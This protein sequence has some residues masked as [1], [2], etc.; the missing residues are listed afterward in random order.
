MHVAA[1]AHGDEGMGVLYWQEFILS[2]HGTLM[3]EATMKLMKEKG[4]IKFTTLA[5]R[6]SAGLCAV[7]Y[8][9]EVVGEKQRRIEPKF[10][11]SKA[12]KSGVKI[13]FGTDAEPIQ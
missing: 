5:D 9:P 8:Y 11:P 6:S 13:A 12:Y 2:K 10:I 3:S 4:L 1:H 7:G